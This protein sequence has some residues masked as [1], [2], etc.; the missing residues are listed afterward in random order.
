MIP[1]GIMSHFLYE[2]NHYIVVDLVLLV[3]L[4]MLAAL[5]IASLGFFVASPMTVSWTITMCAP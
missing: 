2:T 5:P 4:L 3:V 1:I